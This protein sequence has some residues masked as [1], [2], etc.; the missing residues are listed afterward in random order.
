MYLD[1][2]AISKLNNN[3]STSAKREF[4]TCICS[5]YDSCSLCRIADECG[6]TSNHTTPDACTDYQIHKLFE[7]IF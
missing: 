1:S 5:A 6:Q 7:K 3:L 4:L 2:D